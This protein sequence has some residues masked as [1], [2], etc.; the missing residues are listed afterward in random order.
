MDG[1]C[2]GTVRDPDPDVVRNADP[3]ADVVRNADPDADVVRNA[4]GDPDSDADANVVRDS[5]GDAH[6]NTDGHPDRLAHA[7][8]DRDAHAHGF[9]DAHADVDAIHFG[10]TLAAAD[11]HALRDADARR[12]ACR[13]LRQH[14]RTCLADPDRHLGAHPRHA[15]ALKAGAALPGAAWNCPKIQRGDRLLS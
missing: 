9:A 13:H 15:A 3:D 4:D 1:C 10:I 6:R 5:D 12:R 8:T 14:R 11:D 7:D 2:L